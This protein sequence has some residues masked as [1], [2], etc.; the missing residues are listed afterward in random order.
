MP[1]HAIPYLRKKT[2]SSIKKKTPIHKK[3]NQKGKGGT[4]REREERREDQY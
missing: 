4:W 3:K 1:R 2:S